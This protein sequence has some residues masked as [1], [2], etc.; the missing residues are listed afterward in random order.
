MAIVRF[1]IE[2]ERFSPSNKI[3][4]MY[5]I[6]FNA[7]RANETADVRPGA[8]L[9]LICIFSGWLIG[10]ALAAANPSALIDVAVDAGAYCLL[11]IP[12]RI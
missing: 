2:C 1:P 8:H 5:A 11:L 12:N 4:V 6:R 3:G 9:F 7:N 10:Q